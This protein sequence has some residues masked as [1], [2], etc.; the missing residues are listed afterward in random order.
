MI[1]ASTLDA[2][3]LAAR[4]GDTL[5]LVGVFP[6]TRAS[7]PAGV[8]LDARQ[9]VIEGLWYARRVGAA[10]TILG[11]RWA[12]LRTDGAAGLVVRGAVFSGDGGGA[13]LTV[14]RGFGIEVEDSAFEDL[15][16]GISLHTVD[17]F[18]VRRCG[19]ARMS[20]DG[21]TIGLSRNGQI[22]ANR[23]HGSKPAPGAH[24]DAVQLFSRLEAPPTADIVIRGNRV[25]GMTQG[26]CAF[27]KVGGGF[28]RIVIE[29]NDV[30]V[31]YAQAIAIQDGRDCIVR[32][33]RV[34]TYPG[35]FARASI[36]LDRCERTV[37]T[38]NTVAAGRGKPSVNDP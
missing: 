16:T 19:F 20:S 3:L 26:L 32:D 12:G 9:A 8:T 36:N 34:T 21:M 33:N 25:T 13:G 23:F 22:E 29:G 35:A 15:R 4:P 30:C 17:G 18:A 7:L 37:R 5:A 1:T 27:S 31:G 24:A 2:A 11:G 38:G 28:D 14:A 6:A 10:V